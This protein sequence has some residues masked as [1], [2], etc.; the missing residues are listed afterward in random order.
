MSGLVARKRMFKLVYRR[1]GQLNIRLFTEGAD[2]KERRFAVVQPS[3]VEAYAPS[4]A[5][6][7]CAIYQLRA[8]QFGA[9]FCV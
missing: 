5:V 9:P 3:V 4:L 8:H 6:S 7:A 2:L 1:S